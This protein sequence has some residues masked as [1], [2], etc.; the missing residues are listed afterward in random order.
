MSQAF[1]AAKSPT[2][3]G[4]SAERLKR[5]DD[6]M[7]GF[8]DKGMAPNA[9]TFVAR[10]GNIVHYKAY[11]FSNLEKK[12][13]LKRDDIFR[14]ASQSKALVTTTLM[15]LFEE[16]KFMLDEPI[17]KYIPAF[18]NPLVLVSAQQQQPHRGSMLRPAELVLNQRHI[19][20]KLADKLWLE[21]AGL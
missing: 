14:I 15:T 7:Q 12:T 21:L 20:T 18:K 6:L 17:S 13:P 19:E 3:A 9:V 8:V 4:F 2:D 5:V 16:G 11:G 10:N 1:T